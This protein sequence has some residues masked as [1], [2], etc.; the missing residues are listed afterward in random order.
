MLSSQHGDFLIKGISLPS[1]ICLQQVVVLLTGDFAQH[2][3][4]ET[5]KDTHVSS[6][7]LHTCVNTGTP[8]LE[9]ERMEIRK[10]VRNTLS[11]AFMQNNYQK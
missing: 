8:M 10:K 2:A 7:P 6:I 11:I 1:L 9:S 3:F 5:K 4:G